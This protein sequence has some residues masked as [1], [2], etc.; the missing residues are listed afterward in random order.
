MTLSVKTFKRLFLLLLAL[1]ILIPLCLAIHYGRKSAELER[2][3]KGEE[4]RPPVES[5]A[6]ETAGPSE[7]VYSQAVAEAI[8]YQTLYPDLYG[9]REIGAQRVRSANT[10]YLTFDSSLGSNTGRVLDALNRYGVKATFFVSGASD[11]DQAALMS[12]IV[13]E[14]HSIGLSSYS[15]SYQEIYASVPAYL[16]DFQKIYDQVYQNTGIRAEMFRFPGGSVNA[17]NSGIYRELISEMLRRRFVFFDWNVSGED[18]RLTA[19]TGEQIRDNVVS[20]MSGRDRGIVFL[21]DGAGKEAVA[22]ALPGIIESLLNQ[23]YSFQPL[24]ADVLPVVF[25]YQ[26]AP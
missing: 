18:T 17:Y 7:P 11:T 13:A 24:T 21:Q 15:G 26:S 6:A 25:S 1:L 19:Q 2:R 9:A 16:E 20:G 23:G 22:D 3:L 4:T 14:G 5:Q 8:D 12:R 10:V